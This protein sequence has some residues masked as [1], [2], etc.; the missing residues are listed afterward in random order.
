MHQAEMS[1]ETGR[2]R[3]NQ[4]LLVIQTARFTGM[5]SCPFDCEET[6]CLSVADAPNI[7][8]CEDVSQG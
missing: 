7:H 4:I 1:G 5:T 2:S 3:S 6:H 8:H